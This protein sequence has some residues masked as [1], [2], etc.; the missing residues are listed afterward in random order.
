MSR[1]PL[2]PVAGVLL[3]IVSACSHSS[4]EK[5]ARLHG[6]PVTPDI[7][8]ARGE[9]QFEYH[10]RQVLLIENLVKESGLRPTAAA[11]LLDDVRRAGHPTPPVVRPEDFVTHLKDWLAAA[12][13]KDSAQEAAV[14]LIADRAL[15][16]VWQPLALNDTDQAES[17]GAV[18]RLNAMGVQTSLSGDGD[19][20]Y[21]GNWLQTVTAL[22]PKGPM[23]QRAELLLLEIDCGASPSNYHSIVQRLETILAN[24][25][26]SE[27]QFT[28]QV[29][30]GDAYGDVVALAQ[31][32]GRENADSTQFAPEADEA[33]AKA[34]TLY[35][36]ALTI[37]HTSRLA[38]GGQLAHD[39]LASG[40]RVDH[41]RFFCFGE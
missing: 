13:G 26:D 25:A 5:P 37:D 16:A 21:P 18:T 4:P 22:D 36:A 7:V 2:S 38:R 17:V 10:E 15:R 1:S 11:N 9:R 24:P 8:A 29:L 31:G 27:V 34:I 41:T 28:A 39:R 3:C 35:E 19:M 33:R 20:V 14:Y 40:Q 30:E 32:Y 12:D 23:G 6:P